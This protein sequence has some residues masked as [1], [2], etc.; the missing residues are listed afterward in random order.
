MSK[1]RLSQITG[2]SQSSFSK[3]ARQQTSLSVET[4]QRIC[5]AFGITMAQFF[6]ESDEYPDLSP[7]QKY[8]LDYWGLMDKQKQELI[9][10]MIEK[11]YELNNT[12]K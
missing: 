8:M 4:I 2:I 7:Q 5:D 6:S 10:L 9:L 3:M 11:L 12:G 1:Y